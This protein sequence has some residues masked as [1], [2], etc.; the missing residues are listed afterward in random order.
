MELNELTRK[1]TSMQSAAKGRMRDGIGENMQLYLQGYVD[2]LESVMATIRKAMEAE[3][4]RQRL[5]R[6]ESELAQE[7]EPDWSLISATVT[8]STVVTRNNAAKD[9][10]LE[11][12]P[13]S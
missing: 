8:T 11:S 2:G 3:R 5:A 10:P 7:S 6:L 1:I 13:N 12:I 4:M 9:N